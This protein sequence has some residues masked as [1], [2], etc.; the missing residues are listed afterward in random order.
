MNVDP[1]CN[2][3]VSAAPD[4]PRSEYNGTTYYFCCESCKEEF[5]R[6]PDQYV[7]PQP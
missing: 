7:A 4:T 6:H 5:D 2:M 1:V 3:E